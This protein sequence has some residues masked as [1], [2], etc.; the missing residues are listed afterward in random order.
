VEATWQRRGRGELPSA[1]LV[2]GDVLGVVWALVPE[3]DQVVR[4][5]YF[6]AVFWGQ[7]VA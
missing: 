2:G 3:G 1:R 5:D 4:V 6:S 7:V